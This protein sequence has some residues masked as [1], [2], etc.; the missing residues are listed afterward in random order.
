MS[1]DQELGFA[2][3][4]T[5]SQMAKQ[6]EAEESEIDRLKWLESEKAGHDIGRARAYWIW[7]TTY[8]ATWIKRYASGI[9]EVNS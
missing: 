9:S 3:P 2:C 7:V 5:S 1:E 6:H 4:V 8:R